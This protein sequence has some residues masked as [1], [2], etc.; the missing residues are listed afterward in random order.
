MI[1]ICS[2]VYPD[3]NKVEKYL[4]KSFQTGRISNFGPVYWKFVEKLKVYLNLPEDK[5]IVLTSSGHTAL[6]TAYNILD[7]DTCVLPSYTFPSTLQAA[8]IQGVF[9]EIA[10]V[11]LK[12]GCLDLD[13]LDRF[14]HCDTVVA[15]TALSN[16]P[17]LKKI[18]DFV[19]ASQR[20]KLIIDG[21]PSFGTKDICSY[22]D[23]FCFSFHATK[24]L[25]IGEGG[26]LVCSKD[27][28]ERARAFINFGFDE[29]KNLSPYGMN[30]KLSD[31]SCAIGLSVLED[32]D[33]AID[34]RL[35]NASFYREILSDFC[36][37]SW[38][39]STV[40]QTFPIF[41]ES[42]HA[43]KIRSI[44]DENNVQYLQYYQPLGSLTNAKSLYERNICLPVHQDLTLDQ[45][46]YIC[47]LVL[48]V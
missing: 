19:F 48:S 45:V 5:D 8:E 34:R 32:I 23:V 15:T 38:K 21:A 28:V 25:S 42:A 31:Y 20:K 33:I 11:D 43:L 4:S 22:G 16:V 18:E 1:K 35:E 9:C 14:N 40:Y 30:A 3:F 37:E 44:L 7:T 6:M 10:D 46:N 13:Q 47:D 24:T 27:D 26:A 36:L 39:D 29:D 2:P 17:N 12:T 41:V